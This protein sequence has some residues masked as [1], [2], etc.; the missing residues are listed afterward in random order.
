[1]LDRKF[2]LQNPELVSEN[3]ARRG[4]SVD[5]QSICELES[6]RLAALKRSQEFN[7]QAN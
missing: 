1:M 5:V 2:I 7:T 4:V 6:Q 3:S